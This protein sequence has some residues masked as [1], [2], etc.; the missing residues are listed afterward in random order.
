MVVYE[1][2]KDLISK[3][4]GISINRQLCLLN[5]SKGGF[6]YVRKEESAENLEMM[7]SMDQHIAEDPI[8]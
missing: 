3:D 8:D 5:M 6:Y 7:R 2:K 1:V 4:S